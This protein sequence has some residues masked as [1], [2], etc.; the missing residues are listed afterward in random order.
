MF[1][2]KSQVYSEVVIE[3]WGF[4]SVRAIALQ[5]L[6]NMW[7]KHSFLRGIYGDLDSRKTDIYQGFLC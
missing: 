1:V 4:D 6:R 5:M 7:V 2:D 3:E